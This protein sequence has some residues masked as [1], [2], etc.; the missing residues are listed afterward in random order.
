MKRYFIIFFLLLVFVGCK[1]DPKAIN[2]VLDVRNQDIASGISTLVGEWEEFTN[3]LTNPEDLPSTTKNFR[4]LPGVWN[5]KNHSSSN[6][7]QYATYRVTILLGKNRP[8]TLTF[9]SK[10][11]LD[12]Y[13]LYVNN[14]LILSDGDPSTTKANEK[15]SAI[16]KKGT[17]KVTSDTLS[18]VLQVSSFHF[19]ANAGPLN[20]IHFGTKAAVE[21]RLI[22]N[23]TL[24]AL[25]LGIM[26]ILALQ[27]I[28][29]FAQFRQEKSYLYFSLYCIIWVIIG[30]IETD[31]FR[32]ATLLFPNTPFVLLYRLYVPL[33]ASSVAVTCLFFNAVFNFSFLRRALPIILAICSIEVL[34]GL[35]MPLP[36]VAAQ[37]TIFLILIESAILLLFGSVFYGIKNK[38]S[39]S[40]I[41]LIGLAIY[42]AAAINDT[43]NLNSTLNTGFLMLFG[44]TALILSQALVLAIR[45]AQTY[46]QHSDLL[47]HITHKNKELT[48]LSQIKDEFLANISH[49]LRTP[50]HGIIGI[51][52]SI[53]EGKEHVSNFVTSNLKIIEASGKRLI[54]LVNSILDFSKMKH[55]DLSI[56]IKSVDICQEIDM[57]IPHF[58]KIAKTKEITLICSFEK[59]EL[60]V[61]ADEDR[62]A[63]VL[64][65]L[66]GNAVKF[67]DKGS[68]SVSIILKDKRAL[69]EI[70]DTGIGIKESDLQ[71]IFNPFEQ[72]SDNQ[73]NYR[74]G[75]G[76]GLAITKKLIE[77]QAGVLSVSSTLGKGSL[78]SV[79]FPLA[80]K[81][82]SAINLSCHKEMKPH[83]FYSEMNS[84]S[85]SYS[86]TETVQL[87]SENNKSF[88]TVLAI[89]DE[90]VNLQIIKN[91]LV[92]EGLSLVTAN[93]GEHALELIKKH[94]PA[95][96]LLDIMMPGKN[97]YEVCKDLRQQYSSLELPIVFISAKNR[98]ED[99]LIGFEM[100][101]N[102]YILKPFLKQELLARTTMHLKQQQ[103]H[104]VL[105]ENLALKTNLAD[106]VIEREQLQT[107][108]KRLTALLHTIPE[109][110]MLVDSENEIVFINSTFG[111]YIGD[112]KLSEGDSLQ[113]VLTLSHT[114]D[115][116]DL[117][118]STNKKESHYTIK[119]RP[120]EIDS[121]PLNL[122]TSASE[123]SNISSSN[124]IIA[125]LLNSENRIHEIDTIFENEIER[126]AKL[127]DPFCDEQDP[128]ALAV[129]LMVDSLKYWEI[130]TGK[131][132]TNFAEESGIWAVHYDK[133]GWGRTVTLDKYLSI[134]K[135]P[136]F[137]KWKNIFA[138]AKWILKTSTPEDETSQKKAQEIQKQLRVLKKLKMT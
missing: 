53:L 115:S 103:A 89:D 109:P 13:R 86:D 81:N 96:V 47:D 70:T 78:F 122:I 61:L 51:S 114:S 102:D 56:N 9:F 111:K 87:P 19:N 25:I 136:R 104:I 137:P 18:C 128:V 15:P 112:F 38:Q 110:I 82:D 21:Q 7:P 44:V 113:G 14:S 17:V 45:H 124:K 55:N 71:N 83:Q 37:L 105:K 79:S 50:L 90:P 11:Q 22:F 24:Y 74:G 101:A 127:K 34:V 31:N 20:P 119:Y 88:G 40:I 64:F 98:I 1:E 94:S 95:L 138:T 6:P 126:A 75:T 8:D 43:L 10:E 32:F 93:N 118:F 48:R 97:G 107:S 42:V 27:N 54:N 49:E 77:L 131:T 72:A 2:G 106:A 117:I 5:N 76:L 4:F 12:C 57:I 62:L 58:T 23:Y 46:K 99:L 63:Q 69:L 116:G 133:D 130:V 100:G 125:E 36:F 85:Y 30:F 35:F 134:R 129:K 65:N 16:L 123:L 121:E 59:R 68:V 73:N 33:L 91:H 60:F 120:L 39:G 29:L 132:K 66:I 52:E 41:L 135:I 28:V 26:L 80:L 108:Q 3:E 84:D 67:T 92:A